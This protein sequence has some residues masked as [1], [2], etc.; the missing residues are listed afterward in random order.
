MIRRSER[1]GLR[2]PEGM[3]VGEVDLERRVVGNCGGDLAA[4]EAA[5]MEVS[6]S[7]AGRSARGAH[8]NPVC[9]EDRDPVGG[10][11]PGDGLWVRDDLLAPATRLAAGRSLGSIAPCA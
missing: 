5:S 7:Q 6:R 9:I 10:P 4:A 11:S 2:P 1:V 8:W 3:Q